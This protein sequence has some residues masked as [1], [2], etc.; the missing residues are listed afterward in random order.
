MPAPRKYEYTN[1]EELASI[2]RER[3]R[4]S[5]FIHFWKK[6]YN[7][8]VNEEDIDFFKQNKRVIKQA[9]PIINELRNIEFIN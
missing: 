2:R 8:V 7:I 3:D 1:K 4:I 9:I 6:N 5:H